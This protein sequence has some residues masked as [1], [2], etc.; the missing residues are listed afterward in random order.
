[1][2]PR[3]GRIG[4]QFGQ[5]GQCASLGNLGMSGISIRFYSS[6]ISWLS[7]D[8]ALLKP[9]LRQIR[10]GK[11]TAGTSQEKYW[12]LSQQRFSGV[13]F[14]RMFFTMVPFREYEDALNTRGNI[15]VDKRHQKG[16][17]VHILSVSDWN[18]PCK[19]YPNYG[20][21]G[22]Q[23]PPMPAS[24][25]NMPPHMASAGILMPQVHCQWAL[26]LSVHLCI[27]SFR[28]KATRL[29]FS[30]CLEIAVSRLLDGVACI[31]LCVDSTLGS[32]HAAAWRLVFFCLFQ[33]DVSKLSGH[34]GLIGSAAPTF[35][36]K[37]KCTWNGRSCPLL[38]IKRPSV[39]FSF[40]FSARLSASTVIL[41]SFCLVCVCV[42]CVLTLFCLPYVVFWCRSLFSTH[43]SWIS[44]LFSKRTGW[45]SNWSVLRPN[46][47]TLIKSRSCC[48]HLVWTTSS[49]MAK[50]L[51]CCALLLKSNHTDL[52]S[53]LFHLHFQDFKNTAFLPFAIFMSLHLN[54][55]PLHLHVRWIRAEKMILPSI[56][57]SRNLQGAT[58]KT[59]ILP[60]DKLRGCLFWDL[61]F[62]KSR[63][64]ME[65]LEELRLFLVTAHSHTFYPEH[66]WTR[67]DE[68][69]SFEATEIPALILNGWM[70][71]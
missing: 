20:Y 25:S 18:H 40:V 12:N 64:L 56:S 4:I 48:R 17:T 62:S 60:V 24:Q 42:L 11:Q 1:M 30:W 26:R 71:R 38:L 10:P 65:W 33:K 52:W 57:H 9:V 47:S 29:E 5:F 6:Q 39:S 7:L 69:F 67:V 61:V 50:A 46:K 15:T 70:C 22:Q 16:R 37:L 45:A 51:H 54:V 66:E 68:A 32:S 53:G 35:T 49:S 43:C 27:T 19:A 23:P 3:I 13:C 28:K 58:E 21:G 14:S 31:F 8:K 34:C 59:C 44:W 2:S 41:C 63:G 55:S 36:L